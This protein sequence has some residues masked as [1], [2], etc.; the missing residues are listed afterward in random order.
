MENHKD[1]TSKSIEIDNPIAFL[2]K[3]LAENPVPPHPLMADAPFA[4][5]LVGYLGYGA[6]GYT[7]RIAQQKDS[8]RSVPLGR[9]GLYDSFV[10]FDHQYRQITFFSARGEDHIN[11]LIKRSLVQSSLPPLR[12]GLPRTRREHTHAAVT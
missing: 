8:V 7:E 1:G 6:T 11:E 2:R 12:P 9:Y 5:G 10:L 3:I 4:G